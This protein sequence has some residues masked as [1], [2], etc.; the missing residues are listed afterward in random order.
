MKA[1][2]QQQCLN[3]LQTVITP[4]GI[5]WQDIV[6]AVSADMV[7]KNWLY[8]RGV[9]QGMLDRGEITRKPDVFVELYYGK[10]SVQF[11]VE[12]FQDFV[13]SHGFGDATEDGIAQGKLLME[14]G[15]DIA[16]AAAEITARGLTT[17]PETV[18]DEQPVTGMPELC[19]LWN[20][21]A[22]TPVNDEDELDEPFHTFPK[23]TPRADVWHWFEAANSQFKVQEAGVVIG[24]GHPFLSL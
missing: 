1:S 12:E 18:D 7:V 6:K 5:E 8:V 2:Q 14:S 19:A 21:L 13:C 22:D 16:T 17:E 11:D 10:A 23:G 9:M 15:D 20:Q 24:A 3:I 4:A